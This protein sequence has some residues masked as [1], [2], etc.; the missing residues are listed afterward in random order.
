MDASQRS[1]DSDSV[2]DANKTLTSIRS[3]PSETTKDNFQ[4]NVIKE[5]EEPATKQ[6][7]RKPKLKSKQPSKE[8]GSKPDTKENISKP[9]SSVGSKPK[10]DPIL[11][12]END[13]TP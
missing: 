6:E 7:D 8:S 1:K 5:E 13:L 12:V 9:Q 3:P 11:V 4:I 2:S 10:D